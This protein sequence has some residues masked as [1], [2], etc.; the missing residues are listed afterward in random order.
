MD[1][2]ETL[3][4]EEQFAAIEEILEQ[5]EGKDTSLDQTFALYQKGLG[6]VKEANGLLDEMEKAILVLNGQGET[7]PLE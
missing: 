1:K 3:T 6:H 7:E 4:L 5:M 2:A